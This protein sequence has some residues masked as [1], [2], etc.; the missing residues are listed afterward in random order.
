MVEKVIQDAEV[1]FGHQK[2]V[3]EEVVAQLVVFAN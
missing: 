3:M 2:C 1:D